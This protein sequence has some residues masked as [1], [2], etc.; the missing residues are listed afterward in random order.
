[1]AA[2]SS[3]HDD[4]TEEGFFS[5]NQVTLLDFE[6]DSQLTADADP[7]TDSKKHILNQLLYTVGYLNRDNSVSRPGGV[8]LTN[9]VTTPAGAGKQTIR[10]HAKFQVA[11]GG[12][13]QPLGKGQL[14][15][16]TEYGFQLPRDVSDDGLTR[17]AT[18][19]KVGC[20]FD[21]TDEAE[22]AIWYFYQPQQGSCRLDPADVLS[23]A[24]SQ[25][26]GAT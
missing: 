12:G 23:V 17:F 11:W 19:Y 1:V 6:L 24:G 20:T 14:S 2:C 22:N 10:Y 3:A 5:S 4:K 26:H 15:L 7:A 16:P 8:V 9:V 18:K 25:G 13:P 21:D